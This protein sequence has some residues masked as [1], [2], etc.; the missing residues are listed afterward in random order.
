VRATFAL[1]ALAL[2]VACTL[3]DIAAAECRRTPVGQGQELDGPGSFGA[4][5]GTVSLD[6]LKYVGSIQLRDTEYVLI[7]DERG[8]VH[9]LTTGDR[10][11]ENGGVISRID[12]DTIYVQ[13]RLKRDGK[14]RQTVVKFPKKS[15]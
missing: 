1:S 13:Q 6:C 4:L 9:R 5:D 7:Q 3:P 8:T 14:W 2:V 15:G 12:N 11:G 10:M